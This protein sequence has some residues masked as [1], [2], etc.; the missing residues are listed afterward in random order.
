M[1][2]T[3]IILAGG[4]SSRMGEEKALL[5]AG[6]QTLIEHAIKTL[7]PLCTEIVLST[8]SPDLFRAFHLATVKDLTPDLGPLAGIASALGTSETDV[9][10]VIAVDMPGIETDFLSYLLDCFPGNNG[11]VP[12]SETGIL[13]PLC[14]VYSVSLV[15]GI[16]NLL[17]NNRLAAAA[18][19]DLPGVLKLAVTPHTPGYSEEM[20]ANMNTPVD[21]E[22]W[23]L[24]NRR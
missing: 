6:G 20:F 10:I 21:M 14:G 15:P 11:V 23:K 3:G 22:R 7:T 16:E 8:N 17:N 13:Q 5:E 24:A 12:V 1:G 9:N 2:T 4:R 19:T 18:I